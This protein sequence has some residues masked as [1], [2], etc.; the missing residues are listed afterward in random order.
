MADFI[1]VMTN[2]WFT[3]MDVYGQAASAAAFDDTYNE[4]SDIPNQYITKCY[5]SNYVGSVGNYNNENELY[6]LLVTEAYNKHGVCMDYYVTTFNKAYDRIFGEDNDR[7]FERKFKIMGFYQLPREE[8]MWSK[9]GI[10]GLDNF[11]I[12]VS[13]RHFWKASKY[14]ANQTN[15][16][17]YNT[18]IPKV[19][20]Y[21]MA[22]YNKYAYEIV[23]VKDEEM[24]Y[25]QSKQH[26]WEFL[27]RTF[28][29]E[30]IETTSLTSA[31][32]I[33]AV[34]NKDSD[35]FDI[36]TTV[37]GKKND[38]NYNPKSTEE[39]SGDPYGNW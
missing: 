4:Y 13:K 10:E 28:K 37:N 34:T 15:P 26:V 8:K 21:I 30:H 33:S 25:L 39:S 16:D 11:S 1:A 27:V 22:N 23:E 7:R 3:E 31:T 19:G 18:Y 12:Y 17:A 9:F 20:D 29:D 14:D 6:D 36:T 5:A 2:G 38:V 32:D 24:M 35:I